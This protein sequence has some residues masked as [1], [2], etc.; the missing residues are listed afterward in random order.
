MFWLLSTMFE[1]GIECC[2]LY[3]QNWD[4]VFWLLSTMFEVGVECCELYTQN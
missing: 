1:V 4:I 2:E 3:T